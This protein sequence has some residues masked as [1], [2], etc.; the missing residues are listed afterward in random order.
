MKITNRIYLDYQATTPVDPRVLSAMTPYFRDIFANPHSADHTLG[1]E[2]A[3]IVETAASQISQLIG[4]DTDE[5]VFT[6]GATES[7]NLA[8]LGLARRAADGNRRRILLSSIEHRCVLAAGREIRKQC[9]FTVNSIPVD[10]DGFVELAAL[11]NLLDEDVLFVSVMA[12]NNE[13]GTIQPIPQI[14]ELVHSYGAILHCDAA[15]GP[16]AINLHGIA[17]QCDTISL[18]AHKMYG[19]KGIGALFVT[20]DI[21]SQIEPLIYGGSQQNGL[22]P[23]TLPVP[24]CVGMGAAADIFRI[25]RP[26]ERRDD[27]RRKRDTFVEVLKRSRWPITVNGP[28]W[29]NRH[30]GNANLCFS[31]FSAHDIL[32]VLQPHLAASTGAACSSGILGLSHVLRA[33]GLDS[34]QADSSIRFSLGFDTTDEEI[35]IAIWLLEDALAK[36]AKG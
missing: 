1:W 18:S 4:A 29:Q 21:Q 24:L 9:G 23:G 25:D 17:Q 22:R 2:S 36:L 33:M 11:D 12:V 32:G 30:P 16:V 5:I 6:S 3:E 27:L 31:G 8:L 19:P 15:Q 7:N 20:R 35:E 28:Q 14:A 26:E 13:I 34:G 10:K